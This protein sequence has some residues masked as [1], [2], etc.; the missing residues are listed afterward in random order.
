MYNRNQPPPDTP[1]TLNLDSLDQG[2]LLALRAQLDSLLPD[3]NLNNMNLEQEIVRQYKTA[4]ALEAAT[5]A[6]NEEANKKA[7]VLNSANAALQACVKM[8]SDLYTAERFKNI[9]S[10]LIKALEVIPDEH[11]REFLDWYALGEIK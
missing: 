3:M 4:Q 2:T 7:Q 8:Q 6:S 5:L 9:E 10:R 1:N 11:I